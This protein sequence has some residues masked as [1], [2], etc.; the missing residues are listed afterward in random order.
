MLPS[1]IYGCRRWCRGGSNPKIQRATLRRVGTL[2][3]TLWAKLRGE[4]S[5]GNVRRYVIGLLLGVIFVYVNIRIANL[6][7]PMIENLGRASAPTNGV[8]ISE[9]KFLSPLER[10]MMRTM[11]HDARLARAL[12]YLR[13]GGFQGGV[14][15]DMDA[16]RLRLGQND[17]HFDPVQQYINFCFARM[18]EFRRALADHGEDN[19][20]DRVGEDA[21]LFVLLHE[22]G[23]AFLMDR[24]V[25]VLGSIEDA[26]DEFASM[27]AIHTHAPELVVAGA[28]YFELG[29]GPPNVAADDQHAPPA[30]RAYRVRCLVFGASP[31]SYPDWLKQKKA[32]ATCVDDFKMRDAG[33]LTMLHDAKLRDVRPN[34]SQLSL[35]W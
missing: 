10:A 19:H 12:T 21:A 15:I 8:T 34:R 16:C 32:D 28:R 17:T 22:L 31:Q 4:V 11:E 25:P 9:G 27:V 5:P 1:L 33:W 2:N 29:L 7:Y 35:V 13:R 23:H 20:A 26:A 24:G 18:S 6:N 3:R 14:R 30:Q